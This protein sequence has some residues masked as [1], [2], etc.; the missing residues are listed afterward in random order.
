M[1]L[2]TF[3]PADKPNASPAAG[4]VVGDRIVDLAGGASALRLDPLPTTVSALIAAGPHAWDV[5]RE[6]S[7]RAAQTEAARRLEAAG[8]SR[9]LSDV[10]LL[11]PL[12]LRKNVFCVGTNYAEHVAEGCRRRGEPV[13]LPKSAEYFTKAPTSVVGPFDP[14]HL[15]PALSQKWDWEGELAVVIGQQ[16]KRV[17]RERSME[18]IFGYCCFNDVSARDLQHR[19]KQWFLG[20]SLDD[21]SPMGPWIVTADE[22]GNPDD[23][24]LITR[25]NGAVKQ[26]SRTEMIFPI[27]LVISD[28]SQGI[29]LEPGDVIATGTPAGVGNSAIPPQYLHPGD[30][31]ETEIVGIGAMRNRVVEA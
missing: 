19:G 25:V 6:L 7:G 16:A 26:D 20:K 29:T 8:H 12:A 10:Q 2:A 23:A 1:R 18:A 31:L 3:R 9:P 21:S 14:I 17:A 22:F 15:D 13:V 24:R 28:L 4:I 30:V 11:V 27:D 5:A